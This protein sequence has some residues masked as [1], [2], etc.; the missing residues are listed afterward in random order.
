MPLQSLHRWDVTPPEAIEI[1]IGHRIDLKW[2]IEY[3]LRCCRGYR[4]PESTRLAHRLAGGI[5]GSEGRSL[6]YGNAR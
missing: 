1:S 5:V 6:F 2:A 3:T 4:L